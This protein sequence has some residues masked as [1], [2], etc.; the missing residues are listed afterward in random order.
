MYAKE[1][2]IP[3]RAGIQEWLGGR[4]FYMR[5]NAEDGHRLSPV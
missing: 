1:F 2:V 3:A 5:N 4:G